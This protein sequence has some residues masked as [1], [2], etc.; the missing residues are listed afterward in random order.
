MPER[1]I[2]VADQFGPDGK[3]PDGP[4]VTVAKTPPKS[5]P[6][7]PAR[8]KKV[9]GPAGKAKALA[10]PRGKRRLWSV[11]TGYG[12]IIEAARRRTVKDV[13]G[14]PVA[15]DIPELK[16]QFSG[17]PNGGG[18]PVFMNIEFK[19]IGAGETIPQTRDFEC[20]SLDFDAFCR[21]RLPAVREEVLDMD[22]K[23]RE[24]FE[25]ALWEKVCGRPSFGTYYGSAYETANLHWGMFASQQGAAKFILKRNENPMPALEGLPE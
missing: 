7:R 18:D 19:G 5:V 13:H 15:I 16:L 17:Y 4:A 23:E 8:P 22:A 12:I 24:A 10:I 11:G 6:K 21:D 14:D 25:D 3:T 9:V 20:G 1:D 2:E